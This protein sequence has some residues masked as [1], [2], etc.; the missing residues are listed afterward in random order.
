MTVP[1]L[2]SPKILRLSLVPPVLILY[3]LAYMDQG[4]D[5]RAIADF[6]K[7]IEIN[8]TEKQ[9]YVNRGLSFHSARPK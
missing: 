1:S 5:D 9:A 4:N 8:P 7:S 2:I 6:T 3:G